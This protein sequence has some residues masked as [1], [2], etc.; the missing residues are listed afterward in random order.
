MPLAAEIVP[1]LRMAPAAL[2]TP[3]EDAGPAAGYRAEV[4]DTAPGKRGAEHADRADVDAKR[5]VTR[6]RPAIDDPA[7]KGGNVL[8][9]DGAEVVGNEAG[10]SDAAAAE[11]RDVLDQNAGASRCRKGAGIGYAA[12]EGRRVI[13]LDVAGI[14]RIDFAAAGI[15]DSA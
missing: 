4:A 7:G 1:A 14:G 10:I 11:Q 3:D 15:E 9:I 8:D 12:G 6:H 5:Q 2:P 13:D